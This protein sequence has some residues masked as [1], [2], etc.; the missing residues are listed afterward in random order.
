MYKKLNY[1][2]SVMAG[3]YSQAGYM[4]GNLVNLTVGGYFWEQ[5]G[6][7]TSLN[8]TFPDKATYEIG[9]PDP[10]VKAE[11]NTDQEIETRLD[12]KEVPHY[13]EVSAAFTPIHNFVPR[14]QQNIFKSNGDLET[15]GQE[16]FINLTSDGGPSKSSYGNITPQDKFT[17][18]AT[19]KTTNKSSQDQQITNVDTSYTQ[20][21]ANG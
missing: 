15:Y 14:K 2:Q 3:D 16:H 9:I 11:L 17:E 4:E 13:L 10:E 6:F 12:V 18:Y 5:P 19:G 7:F 1:L 21:I 20:G 8:V